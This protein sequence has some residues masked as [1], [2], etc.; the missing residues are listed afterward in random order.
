MLVFTT[1]LKDIEMCVKER[2]LS[3]MEVVQLV[4]DY[5]SEGVRGA[6]ESYLGTNSTGIYHELVDHLQTSFKSCKTFSLI[7]QRF[8]T[9]TCNDLMKWKISL[10]MS[11]KF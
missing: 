4:K 7:G 6:V 1:W 9:A 10:P 2:K 11:F 3:N 5:T 8:F